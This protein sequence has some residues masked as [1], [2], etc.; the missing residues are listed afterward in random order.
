MPHISLS[1]YA[2]KSQETLDEMAGRLHDSLM[3]EPWNMKPTDVSV[4]VA[5]YAAEDFRP[6]V[7]KKIARDTLLIPSDYID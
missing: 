7:E 5:S 3:G 4:S 1:V 6:E 2:G